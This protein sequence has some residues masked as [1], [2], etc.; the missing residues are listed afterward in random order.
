M[1][2]SQWEEY[3][4]N[5]YFQPPCCLCPMQSTTEEY[6]ACKVAQAFRGEHAGEYFARCAM[7]E[8][9]YKGIH[10]WSCTKYEVL[11]KLRQLTWTRSSIRA[12]S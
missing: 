12:D 9:D 6:I 4:V 3:A 11:K 5:H 7:M 1:P 2:P 10:Y 8:C